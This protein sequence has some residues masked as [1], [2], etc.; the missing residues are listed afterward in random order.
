VENEAYLDRRGVRN[1][2]QKPVAG[3]GVSR[4]YQ[5]SV[6]VGGVM[7]WSQELVTRASIRSSCL[8]WVSEDGL[9]T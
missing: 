3:C 9:R 8:K 5:E 4:E 6:T 1:W 2:C 7:S